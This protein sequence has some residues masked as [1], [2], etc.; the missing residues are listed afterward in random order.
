MFH[1]AASFNQDLN[2]WQVGKVGN[3]QVRRPHPRRPP[4][5]RES[6][7]EERMEGG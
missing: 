3:M 1:D 5:G 6:G 4:D 7:L 2:G